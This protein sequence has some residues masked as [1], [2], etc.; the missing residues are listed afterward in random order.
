MAENKP[1]SKIFKTTVMGG[2]AL[3]T[4]L[5][6]VR[7]WHLKWGASIAEVHQSLPGDD[8]VPNPKTVS[9]R[10]ITIRAAAADI[11]PWLVQM[12]QGRGGLYSHAWLENLLGCD[13]HNANKIIPGFQ[14]LQVGDIIRLGPEGYPFFTVTTIKPN[15]ALVLYGGSGT[16]AEYDNDFTSLMPRSYFTSS[17]TFVL[18]PVDKTT[19]RLIV[20]SRSDWNQSLLNKLIYGVFLEIGHF[21]MEQKMLQGIKERAEAMAG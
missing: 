18:N 10:A 14:Q 7:P 13:I 20:R 15:Q 16:Q 9:T 17:W 1:S 8:M 11:W 2:A 4:Y 12:G 6:V 19:T 5:F 3:A 21:V